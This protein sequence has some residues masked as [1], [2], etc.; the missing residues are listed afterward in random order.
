MKFEFDHKTG[1]MRPK[2][3]EEIYFAKSQGG[4]LIVDDKKNDIKYIIERDERITKLFGSFDKDNLNLYDMRNARMIADR[5]VRLFGRDHKYTDYHYFLKGYHMNENFVQKMSDFLD[6]SVWGDIRRR[7]NGSVED[8][9]KEDGEII[10]KLEDGTI[11][12]M[13]RDA[14]AD[15]DIIDFN[16]SK[17]YTFNESGDEPIYVAVIS[18]GKTDV[19]YKYDEDSEDTVNMVRCFEADSTIRKINDFG[20]LRAIMNQDEWDDNDYFDGL[21]IDCHE[22]CTIFKIDG[23][24]EFSV[25]E[26]RDSAID[27]AVDMEEDLLDSTTFTKKD[28]ERFRNVLGDDFLDEKQMKEDLKESQETYYDELDEDD[29]IDELLRMEIIEDSEDYF[30]VDEYGDIDHSLPKFDYNDY[31][32]AYVEKYIDGISDYIDEYISNFGYDG[33]ES[34]IDTRKL[35]EKI[36]EADGPECEIASYDSVEREER[37]DYIT[38]Y[39][40][41]R[42]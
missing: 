18:D 5:V 15:G 12:I 23:F 24:Y 19:Y 42:N 41:R 38:Y 6:E 14:F 22:N 8:I 32:D 31:K 27:D 20:S 7:G 4:G 25:Y 39:I 11:L 29:A 3:D 36:I 16:G 33:I 28:V 13:S 9:K 2:N 30:D 37:I 26:N 10:G 40:Y 35:A 21:E 1:M 17:I 34:Y